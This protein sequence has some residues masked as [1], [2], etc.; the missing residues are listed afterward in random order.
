MYHG[1]NLNMYPVGVKIN[2][3]SFFSPKPDIDPDLTVF[4]YTICF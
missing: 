1:I 3:S 2:P 4:M